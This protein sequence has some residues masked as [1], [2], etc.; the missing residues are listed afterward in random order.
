MPR[1]MLRSPAYEPE[2]VNLI[3]RFVDRNRDVIDVG[4]NIG[5]ISTCFAS[6]ISQSSRVLAIEPVPGAIRL[7][8]NNLRRNNCLHK[9]VIFEGMAGQS[10]GT[11]EIE[12]IPGMEEYSSAVGIHHA[13]ANN[14]TRRTLTVPVETLDNLA[15]LHNL[16]CGFLKI[17]TEGFELD[18]LEGANAVLDMHR[19][20]IFSEA[21][22]K[23]MGPGG[24]SVRQLVQFLMEHNYHVS[25]VV[26]PGERISH[27]FDGELIALPLPHS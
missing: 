19:P 18:V 9:V 8:R 24:R 25:D 22:D 23:L 17:D 27:P 16:S 3:D 15:A 26:S 14:R 2:L 12:T 5:L 4:A 20:V 21:S 10:S 1:R 6:R 13:K 7:L 11:G